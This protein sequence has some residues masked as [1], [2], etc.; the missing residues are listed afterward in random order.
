MV[1]EFYSHSDA[2]Q[3]LRYFEQL[4]ISTGQ[5]PICMQ[6]NSTGCD[7]CLFELE[8]N[9]PVRDDPG[10]R[11][12]LIVYRQQYIANEC[13]R[14]KRINYLK[15]TLQKYKLPIHWQNLATLVI[16]RYPQL[17][18]SPEEIKGL[19]YRNQDVFQV[20]DRGVV[21]LVP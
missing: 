12:L 14:V 5:L 21:K 6:S 7:G 16:Y 18:R 2:Y 8:P 20:D 17:F 9:C 15:K 11:A 13:M 1:D 4:V 10:I 19:V 3:I